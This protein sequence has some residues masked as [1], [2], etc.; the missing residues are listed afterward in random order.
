LDGVACIHFC[1]FCG[2]DDDV[3]SYIVV[4]TEWK[5]TP[6]TRDRPKCHRHSYEYKG[7]SFPRSASFLIIISFFLFPK[8]APS[9]HL[10]SERSKTEPLNSM[11][12]PWRRPDPNKSRFRRP[13]VLGAFE[14]NLI[15]ALCPRHSRRT[16]LHSKPLPLLPME[17][18]SGIWKRLG[19]G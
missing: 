6:P 14:T 9:N 15:L 16:R 4:S 18:G 5:G 1:H 17:Y 8:N 19:A 10:W 2:L 3:E 13:D 7:L 12:F 11:S